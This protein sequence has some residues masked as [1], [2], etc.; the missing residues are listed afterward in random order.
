MG[1]SSV[2]IVA[3]FW[4]VQARLKRVVARHGLP[5]ADQ[6]DCVQETWL[7]LLV[8]DPDWSLDD[9]KTWRWLQRVVHNKAMDVHR[10]RGR[11]AFEPLDGQVR[12]L[13]SPVSPDHPGR[14]DFDSRPTPALTLDRVAEALEELAGV[15]RTVFTQHARDGATFAAIGRG[16]GLTAGQA[17]ARY[18]RALLRVRSRI[19][20]QSIHAAMGGV[21]LGPRQRPHERERLND[22][23]YIDRIPEFGDF[24]EFFHRLS[25]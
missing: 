3:V 16:L 5:E 15:D 24:L 14:L 25:P 11:H 20:I 13:A 9:P 19:G 17:S 2:A 18:N 8:R 4:R 1:E 12:I 7:A 10:R 22:L 6:E 23:G 21:S